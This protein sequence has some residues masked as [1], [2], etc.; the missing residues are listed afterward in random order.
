MQKYDLISVIIPTYNR[1]YC[2]GNAIHS[3]LEQTYS[4]IELLVIDDG[5][6]DE[7]EKVISSI[8]DNRLKYIKLEKNVGP[9][10]ARNEGI[11]R[12][13]GE[14]IAFQDSDDIWHNNKLAEQYKVMNKN[15]D[16]QL[17]FCK[18]KIITAD[19]KI[20]P[21]EDFFDVSKYR[22]GMFE[23][24]LNEN[25]IGTPAILVRKSMLEKVGG[26][27][28]NLSTLE[29]WE[30]CLRIAE[31]GNIEYINKVLLDVYPSSDGV[32][33]ISDTRRI[34]T[35]LH[36][37]SLYWSKYHSINLFK[38]LI[39]RIID[40]LYLLPEEE[41]GIVEKQLEKTIPEGSF[42][43]KQIVYQVNEIIKRNKHINSLDEHIDCLD[44]HIDYLDGQIK[45]QNSKNI[46]NIWKKNILLSLFDY[47]SGKKTINQLPEKV[48]IYGC[49]EIGRVLIAVCEKAGKKVVSTIDINGKKYNSIPNVSD[50][51][52]INR[53][54]PIII[55][56]PDQSKEIYKELKKYCNADIL[57]IEELFQ[58]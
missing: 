43:V 1:E 2:L 3:V 46:I 20:V 57:N 28:N 53:D 18:Y 13:K 30:L 17:V 36:I 21:E 19:N 23:I 10:R 15:P 7:T 39:I 42:L 56:L 26:F 11:K 37:L 9:S 14:Y 6:T 34:K 54:I 51:S 33:Q 50:F 44:K 29:D 41:R 38:S 48:S 49:G 22:Y 45:I 58:Y 12:A 32:N 8:K 27:N 31:Q 47:Y 24:L 16:C 25:K 35:F 55:T 5:S 4:N 52:E 40:D